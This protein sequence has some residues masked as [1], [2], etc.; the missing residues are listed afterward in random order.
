MPAKAYAEVQ[1]V[2]YG[3]EV[4][5]AVAYAGMRLADAWRF[6]LVPGGR[7]GDRIIGAADIAPVLTPF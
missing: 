3:Y 4:A 6:A 7:T 1:G 5:H 2:A